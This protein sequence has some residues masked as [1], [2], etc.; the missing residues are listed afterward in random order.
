MLCPECGQRLRVVSSRTFESTKNPFGASAKL[1][2]EAQ[3][4][5]DWYTSDWVARHRKCGK[6]SWKKFTVEVTI[7]DFRE[8]KR[9]IAN[10]EA[11][12]Q[13]R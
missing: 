13:T 11:D 5:V 2:A 4:A 8:M 9:L 7:E 6:C 10:G 12:G 1:L 3:D